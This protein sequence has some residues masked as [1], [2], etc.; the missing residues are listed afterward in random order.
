MAAPLVDGEVHGILIT[1]V[2]PNRPR[3]FEARE[4]IFGELGVEDVPKADDWGWRKTNQ[5]LDEPVRPKLEIFESNV[6][7]ILLAVPA[8][9]RLADGFTYH[10]SSGSIGTYNKDRE[11]L[12]RRVW[13]SPAP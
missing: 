13:C 7:F 3:T 8:M 10:L 11:F 9:R 2:D 1:A 4:Q 6:G 5:L 12:H